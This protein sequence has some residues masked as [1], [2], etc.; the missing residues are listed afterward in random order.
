VVPFSDARPNGN[1]RRELVERR[2]PS[3]RFGA[4]PDRLHLHARNSGQLHHL[5]L[6][7][8]AVPRSRFR[9][10]RGHSAHPLL[11]GSVYIIEARSLVRFLR[12]FGRTPITSTPKRNSS[13]RGQTRC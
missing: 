10:K 6:E 5:Q 7:M 11:S 3:V 9:L 2:M 1:L 4:R 13:P 8:Q 12:L